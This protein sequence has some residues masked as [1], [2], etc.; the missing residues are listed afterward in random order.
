MSFNCAEA[1]SCGTVSYKVASDGRPASARPSAATPS[2]P[3]IPPSALRAP[4]PPSRVPTDA[5]SAETPLEQPVS[6]TEPATEQGFRVL[7]N[8]GVPETDNAAVTLS[9]VG[10]PATAFMSISNESDFEGASQ[11]PYAT[12]KL[13]TLLEGEGER[14]VYAKFF[15]EFGYASPV[16]S[17]AI[18]LQTGATPDPSGRGEGSATGATPSRELLTPPTERFS[19]NLHLGS[20]GPEVRALQVFLN[21]NGFSVAERGS[22]SRSQETTY[23]G[24]LTA[25]ALARFQ[26]VYGIGESGF[27]LETRAFLGAFMPAVTPALPAPLAPTVFLRTLELGMTGDDVRALQ[28]RLNALGFRVAERGPGSPGQ[29]SRYFGR[30]TEG[31]LR[32]FQAARGLPQTGVLDEATRAALNMVY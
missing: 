22:G 25:S 16:V 24:R 8:N 1:S 21:V 30:R 18:M 14:T 15:T 28:E 2:A 26:K 13:W 32:A 7:I 5:S 20:V 10:G 29:E 17:D 31:A 23:F 9:L 12:Q 6:E 27:G 11:E 19:E 4:T 3:S